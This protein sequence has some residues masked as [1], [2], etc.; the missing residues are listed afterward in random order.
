MRARHE[1][2]SFALSRADKP[3]AKI[4]RL[5]R[6]IRRHSSSPRAIVIHETRSL[7]LLWQLC[8]PQFAR[9]NSHLARLAGYRRADYAKRSSVTIT[10]RWKC[11]EVLAGFAQ[12][13]HPAPLSLGWSFRRRGRLI[14]GLASRASSP[15]PVT[16][17]APLSL[18]LSL[19][20]PRF[21]KFAETVSSAWQVNQS[22]G[23]FRTPGLRADAAVP[24]DLFAA[25]ISC[26]ICDV[27]RRQNEPFPMS[28]YLALGGYIGR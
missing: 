20:W 11:S 3:K 16:A 27:A 14:S 21:R 17:F 28:P 23:I 15:S 8:P 22:L 4:S 7:R 5:A 24:N 10:I 2:H 25:E 12:R 1:S 19:S 9:T 13:S 6:S 26:R 18:S